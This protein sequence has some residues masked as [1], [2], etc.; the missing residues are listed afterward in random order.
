MWKISRSCLYSS[1]K[2]TTVMGE[3]HHL[4]DKKDSNLNQLQWRQ[5][6]NWV[7]GDVLGSLSGSQIGEIVQ[8]VSKHPNQARFHDLMHRFG[9]RLDRLMDGIDPK[10][11]L[12]LVRSYTEAGLHVVS[13]EVNRHKKNQVRE[14]QNIARSIIPRLIQRGEESSDSDPIESVYVTA[15]CWEQGLVDRSSLRTDTVIKRGFDMIRERDDIPIATRAEFAWGASRVAGGHGNMT[16]P[17]KDIQKLYTLHDLRLFEYYKNLVS[18]PLAT[19]RDWFRVVQLLEATGQNTIHEIVMKS[20]EDKSTVCGSMASQ[21]LW[22]RAISGGRFDS[23]SAQ[24][25]QVCMDKVDSMP[26]VDKWKA[27]SSLVYY[28]TK[29]VPTDRLSDQLQ[30]CNTNDLLGRPKRAAVAWRRDGNNRI[31]YSYHR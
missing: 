12:Q 24:C 11:A 19:R 10:T 31:S 13:P 1:H 27:R 20:L 15:M 9:E 8:Y 22:W 25:M 4:V 2:A 16:L 28:G 21:V 6:F 17:Q 3:F 30:F 7:D 18:M 26:D 14:A 23:I 5:F 29:S